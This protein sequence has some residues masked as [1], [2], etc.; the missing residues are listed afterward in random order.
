M[1]Q[2]LQDQYEVLYIDL[3]ER[4]QDELE[5]DI[6]L[7]QPTII[8]EEIDSIGNQKLKVYVNVVNRLHKK[9]DLVV[10][11]TH[12]VFLD[13][14]NRGGPLPLTID[15]VHMTSTGNALMAK[16]WLETVLE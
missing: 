1:D 13:Y 14:I 7:M 8:K 3:I 12:Q 2:D 4:T 9:Y 5:A 15:G 16:T 10:V 11:P 6:I